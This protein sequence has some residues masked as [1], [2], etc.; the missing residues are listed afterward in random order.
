MSKYYNFKA[1]NDIPISS[2]AEA[3]GIVPEKGN[4]NVLRCKIRQERTA[5]AELHLDTNSWCDRGMQSQNLESSCAGGNNINLVMFL[6]NCSAYEAAG[7]L[8]DMFGIPHIEGKR[9]FIESNFLSNAQWEKIGID[10]TRA[11][12]NMDMSDCDFE[13][14]QRY[15]LS[16]NE[17]R[18]RDPVAYENIMRKVALPFVL[19]SKG[20]YYRMIFDSINIYKA[21]GEEVDPE[22]IPL[23][24]L[25]SNEDETL[26]M[27]ER[28]TLLMR[29]LRG[30]DVRYY[31]TAFDV[32]TDIRKIL[33]GSVPVQVSEMS[34]YQLK[35]DCLR[36]GVKPNYCVVNLE[37]YYNLLE[38]GL[39][40]VEHAAFAKGE[41]INIAFNPM[42]SERIN[43]LIKQQL[44]PA[45]KTPHTP[46]SKA[47]NTDIP[48]QNEPER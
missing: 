35:K 28:Q 21:C 20:S 42:D 16:V 24:L 38:N 47:K 17:L 44:I 48:A 7:M 12:L 18:K 46:E 26:V 19:E 31:P 43:F 22:N 45:F 3:F 10:G 15:S 32:Q 11:S 27:S 6:E 30:T 34:N 23:F 36:H 37:N 39:N 14:A 9:D 8:S 33:T 5:S 1:I 13:R 40:E 29:A 4:G 41:V 25:K 2:V